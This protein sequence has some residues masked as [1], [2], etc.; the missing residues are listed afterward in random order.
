MPRM[1]GRR[2]LLALLQQEGIELVFGNPGTTELLL[3]DELAGTPDLRYVLGLMEAAVMA[4]ADGYAQA[5][6]RPVFVNLHAAPRLGNALGM[7]YDAQKA[8]SPIIVSAGQH[9][10]SLALT[11]PALWGDLVTIAAPFVKWAYE[12]RRAADLPRAVH[13]AVKTALA[14]PTGP[15]F[16][17]LPADVLAE[18]ADID[19]GAPTRVAPLLRADPDAIARAAALLAEAERPVVVAGDAV[20]QSRAGKELAEL[21]EL[22][23]APVLLEGMANTNIFPANHPLFRGPLTRAAAAVRSALDPHD[24]I[25]SVGGDLVTL[26]MASETAPLP[27]GI[28]IV[29]L[30]TNAWEIG[31]NYPAEVGLLGD[32]KTTL[33]ELTRALRTH[34]HGRAAARAETRRMALE[35]AIAEERRAL[36]ARAEAAREKMPIQPLALMQA[37]GAALP[38][39]AV[40]VDESISSGAGLRQFLKGQGP[41][42]YFGVRGGGIGWGI[43]AA[44][45]V[46]LA[47]PDRPVVALI[48]DGSALYTAQAL[49]TAA[50]ERLAIV[51]V[52]LN[53]RSYRILKQRLRALGGV[54][55]GRNLY[56]GMDLTD[57]PVGFLQLAQAFGL[58]AVAAETLPE[59][60]EAV[61]RALAAK[62]P[63]LI[64]VAIDP[65]F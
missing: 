56:P 2:A 32:P 58:Q 49:W 23:G 27:P 34:L 1:S 33:P 54:A 57:P 53:N 5:S 55:A 44:I 37:L 60:I 8:G 43:P 36:A 17:S 10:Q 65:A 7:L 46:K 22:L 26:V 18:E 4:M 20:S 40:V 29:H 64:E 13:R 42:S 35:Q 52:V 41:D 6:G 14:P 62:A 11:E 31:K 47:L 16:L 51:F 21:V 12:P 38:E 24:L 61:Q 19:L 3:M 59:A 28:R 48:G 63:T 25:F 39:N 30:D 9:D 45:G 15:V 50:H